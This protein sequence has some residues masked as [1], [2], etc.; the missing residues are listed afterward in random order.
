MAAETLCAL[1]RPDLGR[2]LACLDH[3]LF[4]ACAQFAANLHNG[5]L[6]Y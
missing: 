4:E 2:L 1:V 5:W 3:A 6:G